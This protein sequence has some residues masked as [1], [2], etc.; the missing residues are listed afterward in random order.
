MYTEAYKIFQEEKYKEKSLKCYNWFLGENSKNVPLIDEETGGCYD[1]ITKEGVNLNE[2]AE[3]MI[4]LI[5]TDMVVNHTE[6]VFK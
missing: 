2:G 4:S 3:S 5:I 1:G 6:T